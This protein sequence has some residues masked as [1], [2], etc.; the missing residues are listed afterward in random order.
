MEQKTLRRADLIFSIVLILISIYVF[1][2]S[3]A[4]LINPFGR[5]FAKLSGDRIKDNIINWFV[6]PALM[7]FLLS[8]FLFFCALMLFRNARREGARFDFIKWPKLVDLV[9]Q[10]E[11]YAF[12][13]VA[14]FLC[15]YIFVFM[16]LCRKYMNFFPAF[17]AFPF[18]VAT[19]LYL[20]LMMI[21]FNQKTWKKVLLS[22]L[23]AACSAGFIAVGF[24]VLAMIP[25]P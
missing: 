16:P 2:T 17:Q 3:I 21:V 14:L 1:I 11:T 20:A 8:L 18:M 22:I 15:L 19:F 23:V 5:D 24:G 9:K 4:L 12:F 13:I 25:L 6:S 10:R 7:P